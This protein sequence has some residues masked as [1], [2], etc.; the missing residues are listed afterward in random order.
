LHTV[1]APQT[2]ERIINFFPPH[3]HQ[4]IC[5]QLSVLLKGV[6]SLRL[7]PLKDGTDRVPACEIMLLSPTISRLIRENKIWE[8]TKFIE[9]SEVFGMQSF[10]QSLIKLVKDGKISEEEA[11]SFSDNK[12]DFVLA[13]KGIKK[14]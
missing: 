12:D 11:M 7:I 1:N 4:Q 2:I 10:D 13:L 9:E 3:Q 8:I 6:I 5:T 14:R